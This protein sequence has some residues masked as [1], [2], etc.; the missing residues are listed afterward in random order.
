MSQKN[1]KSKSQTSGTEPTR[2]S[3]NQVTP[4]K[5]AFIEDS[6][7][8]VI[9]SQK[10]GYTRNGQDIVQSRVISNYSE[11]NKKLFVGGSTT[12]R[13]PEQLSGETT[14]PTGLINDLLSIN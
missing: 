12:P 9:T 2:Y 14:L 11:K 6:G 5:A 8:V 10:N 1:F 3:F 4:I 13:S 7:S